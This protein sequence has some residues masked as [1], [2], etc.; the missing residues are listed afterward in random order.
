MI[1]IHM[2]KGINPHFYIFPDCLTRLAAGNMNIHISTQFSDFQTSLELSQSQVMSSL[3]GHFIRLK[4]SV[5]DGTY[6]L[7]VWNWNKK[8]SKIGQINANI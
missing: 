3:M 4:A 2:L 6:V 8:L 5:H 1:V 7:A